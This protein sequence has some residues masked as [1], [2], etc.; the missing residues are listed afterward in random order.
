MTPRPSHYSVRP[1]RHSR[2]PS[3]PV[4]NGF[5]TPSVNRRT[6][7]TRPDSRQ[8]LQSSNGLPSS[9]SLTQIRGLIGKMQKLEQRVQSARSKLP[10]PMSTPPRAAT[11]PGSALSQSY[12]PATVTVRSQKRRTGGSNISGASSFLTVS[13]GPSDLTPLGMQESHHSS[14]GMLPP[15][16]TRD[17]PHAADGNSRPSSRASISSRQP[18]NHIPNSHPTSRTGRRPSS[19]QSMSISDARTSLA[20]Y[21]SSTAS[22]ETRARPRSSLSGSFASNHGHGHSGSV[23]RLSNYHLD[24]SADGGDVLTPTPSRRTTLSKEGT[25][26]PLPGALGKKL[27]SAGIGGVGRRISSGPGVGEMGPPLE[28]RP[29]AKKL[30]GVGET[31]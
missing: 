20:H 7:L 19:R 26:I 3:I 8:G 17:N 27:S 30:D 14:F 9:T 11:R 18:S 12:I 21:S 10:A 13:K 31:F 15:T 2:G 24:E 29:A 28:R 6:T 23:S 1:P 16:P 4:I 25:G 5:S 22:S